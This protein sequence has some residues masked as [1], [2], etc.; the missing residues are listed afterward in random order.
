[1]PITY[2]LTETPAPED[3]AILELGLTNYFTQQGAG[4]KDNKLA[5]F[6]RDDHG[7]LIAGLIA[8]TGWDQMYIDTLFVAETAR[9]QGIGTGLIAQAET[10]AR[11][12]NCRTVWLMTST[13]EGKSFYERQAYECFGAVE[14]HAP[15]CARYFMKKAL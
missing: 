12:R 15:N 9:G 11:R 1:M 7:V 2:T 4:P 5:I 10:E 3:I 14:R 8:K 13:T 6:A